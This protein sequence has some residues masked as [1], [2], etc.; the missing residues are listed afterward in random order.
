MVLPE[1]LETVQ[2]ADQRQI[3]SV[4]SQWH[5]LKQPETKKK[6]KQKTHMMNTLRIS[7]LDQKIGLNK[8]L[9]YS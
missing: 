3:F 9:S 2:L 7:I 4:N 1:L 8:Y 6:H 5:T